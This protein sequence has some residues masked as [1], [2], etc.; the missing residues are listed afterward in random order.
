M[1]VWVID[2][3]RRIFRLDC[4]LLNDML[5]SAAGRWLKS[6]DE[7]IV[8]GSD[9]HISAQGPPSH[10]QDTD[11]YIR[12]MLASHRSV[13]SGDSSPSV[14]QRDETDKKSYHELHSPAQLTE[15]ESDEP[16]ALAVNSS[17]SSPINALRYY[18][19]LVGK[20]ALLT[21]SAL[22]TLHIGSSVAQR[23]FRSKNFK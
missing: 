3:L 9:G 15:N 2:S 21:F 17:A 20:P 6:A 18:M 16:P 19:S 22:V 10:L 5:M 8:L 1:M 12:S 13:E 4:R 7:V 14:A 11:L 23:G